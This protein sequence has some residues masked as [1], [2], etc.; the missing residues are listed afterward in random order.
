M[1]GEVV[2]GIVS[3]LIRIEGLIFPVASSNVPLVR[4][5]TEVR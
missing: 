3:A 5:A 4:R 1:A 2:S